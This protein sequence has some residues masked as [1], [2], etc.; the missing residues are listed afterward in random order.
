M[1]R[2]LYRNRVATTIIRYCAVIN[3]SIVSP[4]FFFSNFFCLSYRK[5]IGIQF[6]RSQIINYYNYYVKISL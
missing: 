3:F 2:D 5:R 4:F 1:C 6:N